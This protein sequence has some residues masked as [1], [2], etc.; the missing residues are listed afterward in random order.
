MHENG[1]ESQCFRV[2]VQEKLKLFEQLGHN[3]F[4]ASQ[5]M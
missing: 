5:S 1:Q 3:A 4:Y 2:N